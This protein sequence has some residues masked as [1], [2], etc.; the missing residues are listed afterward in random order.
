M[1]D[2]AGEIQAVIACAIPQPGIQG[3]AEGRG[4][5]AFESQDAAQNEV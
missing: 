2:D 5:I 4:A 3:L 1:C